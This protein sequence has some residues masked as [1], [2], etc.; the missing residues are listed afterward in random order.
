M[1]YASLYENTNKTDNYRMYL[2]ADVMRLIPDVEWVKVYKSAKGYL[3]IMPVD[4]DT[5]EKK[6]LLYRQNGRFG[7]ISLNKFVTSGLL[8]K[9]YFGYKYKIKRDKAGNL[10]VCLNEPLGGDGDTASV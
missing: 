2:S 8:P 7:Q 5:P 6:H 9:R 10:Y 4:K 1:Y 3:V